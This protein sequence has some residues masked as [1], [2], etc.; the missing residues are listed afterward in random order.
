MIACA[1]PPVVDG[2]APTSSAQGRQPAGPQSLGNLEIIYVYIYIY[3][4]DVYIYIY[5]EREM[6]GVYIYIYIYTY[7]YISTQMSTL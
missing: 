6:L 1:A 4:Y 2:R 7:T 3:I 5:R